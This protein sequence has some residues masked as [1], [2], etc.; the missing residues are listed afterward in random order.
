MTKD[1]LVDLEDTLKMIKSY[2]FNDRYSW[3]KNS[4]VYGRISQCYAFS[5]EDL[6]WYYPLFNIKDNDIL[7]VCGSG[8]QVLSAIL[9]GAKSIDVFDSN[10]LAYYHLMLKMGAIK[11]LDYEDF[12]KFYT[13]DKYNKDRND[14][15][16][17]ILKNIDDINVKLFWEKMLFG[18]ID[19]SH[20]FLGCHVSPM[21]I[22]SKIPYLDIDNYKIL[23]NMLNNAEI[24]FENIDI[25]E[26]INSFTKKYGFINF[27]NILYYIYDKEAYVNFIKLLSDNNLQ[28]QGSIL[29]NY[30][31]DNSL[32]DKKNEIVYQNLNV[33]SYTSPY[34]DYIKSKNVCYEVKVYSKFKSV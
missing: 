2:N 29:L 12:I 11:G 34:C 13:L 17:V 20:C 1:V 33:Y 30:Y 4:S 6:S 9:Y 26:T 19:L 18:N 14:Y 10:K 28:E 25:F 22:K 31:W 23:K 32:P 27:S 16:K 3:M 21:L 24:H 15:S 7:T 5:N 8:D